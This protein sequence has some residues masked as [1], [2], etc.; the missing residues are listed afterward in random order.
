MSLG[1]LMSYQ[2]RV[3]NICSSLNQ[4][5]GV[6]LLSLFEESD[7]HSRQDLRFPLLRWLL[8]SRVG[9]VP[10]P[11]LIGR[12]RAQV[13]R[14]D[15]KALGLIDIALVLD[16]LD[17]DTDAFL[18]EDDVLGFELV[19][20]CFTNAEEGDIEMVA[21]EG[22]DAHEEEDKEGGEELVVGWEIVGWLWSFDFEGFFWGS[23]GLDKG[24]GVRTLELSAGAGVL[25]GLR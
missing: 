1:I 7:L 8:L 20:C 16:L 10:K 4:R 18:G 23:G 12:P 17:A 24:F 14:L 19:V 3:V 11:A 2:K 22:G 25:W 5:H 13:P 21:D 15:N 9:L 6:Q